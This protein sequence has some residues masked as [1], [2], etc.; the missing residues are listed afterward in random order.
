MDTY[1]LKMLIYSST[2]HLQYKVY[3]QIAAYNV[4][5]DIYS[6]LWMNIPFLCCPTIDLYYKVQSSGSL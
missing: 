6:T 3:N 2:M 5:T 4:P 1:E